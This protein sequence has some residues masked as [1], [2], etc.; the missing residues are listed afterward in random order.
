MALKIQDLKD[1]RNKFVEFHQ[2]YQER[3]FNDI[4]FYQKEIQKID[5]QIEALETED[6]QK[7]EKVLDL[8]EF[9]HQNLAYSSPEDE[10]RLARIV[11]DQIIPHSAGPLSQADQEL[12]RRITIA[13]ALSERQC[14]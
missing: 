8:A 6:L 5:Q 9:F 1:R 12:L 2:F 4:N 7:T 10:L 11:V 14:V 3:G 13:S